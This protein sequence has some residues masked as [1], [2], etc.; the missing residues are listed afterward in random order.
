MC[1][2]QQQQR[3]GSAKE[4]AMAVTVFSSA[5][6]LSLSLAVY[7]SC[8]C[9]LVATRCLFALLMNNLPR[10]FVNGQPKE[11][12]RERERGEW[13]SLKSWTWVS[14]SRL[15]LPLFHS[16]PLFP[17][18]S[19]PLF[20]CAGCSLN[21]FSCGCVCG[22]KLCLFVVRHWDWDWYTDF[23]FDKSLW[24]LF[25]ASFF[26][27]MNEPSRV[28]SSRD[29]ATQADSSRPS[30]TEL[31]WAEPGWTELNWLSDRQCQTWRWTT[32]NWT[33]HGGYTE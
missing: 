3:R 16:L 33:L 25:Y 13:K 30:W 5:S 9:W 1:R 31:S 22:W 7:L 4:R 10:T 29:E 11:R 32:A 14:F 12:G 15:A 8:S 20:L 6:P 2:K 18:H 21:S 27:N 24:N 23:G 19:L 17:S 28:E 26:H